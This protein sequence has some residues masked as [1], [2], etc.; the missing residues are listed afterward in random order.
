MDNGRF[1][2]YRTKILFVRSVTSSK[3]I[4]S[5]VKAK[6]ILENGQ[7]MVITLLIHFENHYYVKLLC[8]ELVKVL[9]TTHLINLRTK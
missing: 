6:S 8:R 3:K 4:N 9:S 1:K 5:M 7:N 2:L